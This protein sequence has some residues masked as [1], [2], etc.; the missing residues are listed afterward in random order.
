MS[1]FD[2]NPYPAG[3]SMRT[4]TPTGTAAIPRSS[5]GNTGIFTPGYTS[6]GYQPSAP[7]GTT[8]TT[9]PPAAPQPTAPATGGDAQSQFLAIMGG[10]PATPQNLVSKEAALIAAGFRVVRSGDGTAGKI[11]IPGGQIVDV[12]HGAHAGGGGA[13]QW[14]TGPSGPSGGQGQAGGFSGGFGSLG[15]LMNGGTDYA[16]RLPALEKT[17]GFQFRM[18]QGVQALDRSAAAKGT[19]LTGGHLKDLTEFGQG[20]ASTEYGNEFGRMFGLAGLGQQAAGALGQYGTSYGSNLT[21]LTTGTGNARAN[22]AIG[23]GNAFSGALGN[24]GNIGAAA[25]YGYNNRNRPQPDYNSYLMPGGYE[26]KGY[27][28]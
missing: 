25:V 11:A 17:P 19:L 20:L 3:G 22:A 7:T 6:G 13:W 15:G 8:A 21:D 16:A 18:N 27:T 5:D 28:S 14:L 23:Q 12:I 9:P 26:D 10:L 24:I 1:W 2:D 4:G